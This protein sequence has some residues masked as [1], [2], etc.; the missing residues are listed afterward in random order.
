MKLEE[1]KG[2]GCPDGMVE[3]P[4]LFSEQTD[5]PRR[6]HIQQPVP[7]NTKALATLKSIPANYC[8]LTQE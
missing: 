7:K 1:S 5:S 2:G 3:T 4:G 8:L 6:P